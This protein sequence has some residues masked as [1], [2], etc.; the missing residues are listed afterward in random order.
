MIM[1]HSSCCP[2]E[3]TPPKEDDAS[4]CGTTAN[5]TGKRRFDY[6]LW[7]SLSLV[8]VAYGIHALGLE[9]ALPTQLSAF[10]AGVFD[11]LNK[12]WWGVLFGIF[13]V[14][15]LGQV[16]REIV[17]AMLGN[18]NG[19][20]GVLRAAVAGIV[21]DLCSHGILMVGVK[22]YERGASLGQLMAFL[23]ASPWNSLSLT[24]I[25]WALIGFKWMMSFLLLSFLIAVVSGVIFDALVGR[26]VL[27]ANP[28]RFELPEG[29]NLKAEL[30]RLFRRIRPHPAAFGEML[31][32]GVK[33]S[34]AVLKWLFFGVVMAAGI[35]AFVDASTFA[36]MFGPSLLGLAFTL[37]AAT[38]IEV[39]SEGSTPIAADILT[40]AGAPGNSFAF[41]MT[42]ISTDYTE[43]MVLRE[44]T[45]SWKIALFLPLVTV[46]QVVLISYILN[47]FAIH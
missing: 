42:G 37:V 38:V 5:A 34:R 28:N 45:N 14:G 8:V 22:L 10:T 47:M 2:P 20:R 43:I 26:G 29:Y 6:L 17:V 12:M 16:P 23:I 1:K 18:D 33:G 40:K 41:L 30:G 31:L 13:F 7:G 36:G 19:W 3:P 4:C 25:L 32:E 35:R 39:C 15:L 46:P 9:T 24:L 44:T 27:P 11:L 21:L